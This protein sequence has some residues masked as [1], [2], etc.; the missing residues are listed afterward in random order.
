MKILGIETSCDETSAAV[1]EK[2]DKKVFIKSNV[3]ASSLAFHAKTG[4][5]IPETAAREQVRYIIPVVIEALIGKG[6]DLTQEEKFIKANEVLKK[7]ID[8]VAVTVGPGLIGSLLV[9]V[10]TAKVFSY[11][12]NKP[13]IPVN[14]LLGHI[15]ANFVTNSKLKT[16]NSKLSETLNFPFIGLIVSGGHTDLLLFKSHTNCKWLGGT[17]DDAAGEAMDKLA[18]ILGL[19]YPGG[20]EI[21]KRAKSGKKGVYNFKSPML[22]SFDFDFSFSGLKTQVPR[23]LKNIDKLSEQQINDVCF[24]VQKAIVDVLVKK[25]VGAA[26][27]HNCSTIVIGGGVSANQT[28]RNQMSLSAR[29]YLLDDKVYYP[30]LEYCSD[31][32]A[33]IGTYALF[34]YNPKPW[35]KV[36]A[37]PELYFS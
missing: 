26:K 8:A 28:L 12:L 3:T 18:R 21:E 16:Q 37:K 11:T 23:E 19:P 35:N 29:R 4:G 24:A 36:S 1:V 6:D 33:M 5:I 32:A 27:E 14:H 30:Q 13:L 2:K 34:N 22:D 17:R 31:N 25:T 15:Y 20:P 9:G 7:E 10:E